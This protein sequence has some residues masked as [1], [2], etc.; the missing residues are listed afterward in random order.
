MLEKVLA[1]LLVVGEMHTLTGKTRLQKL[2][3]LVEANLTQGS[4]SPGYRFQLHYYGPFSF[5]LAHVVDQLVDQQLLAEQS[6]VTPSGNIV[7]SYWVTPE[8]REFVTEVLARE[9]GYED[10]AR[11]VARVIHEYGYVSLER[12]IEKAYEAYPRVEA[13]GNPP[14][15]A[16]GA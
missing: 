8:G 4:R 3:C 5:D 11:D 13:H 15:N 16:A 9:P 1:P 7:F 10:L 14:A 6:Q 12:L 2:M